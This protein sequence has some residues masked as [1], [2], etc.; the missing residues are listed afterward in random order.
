M[1]HLHSLLQGLCGAALAGAL[2]GLGEAAWLL[3]SGGAPDLLS[4][5]YAVCL[6]G[7]IAAPI[8]AGVGLLASAAKV[9]PGVAWGLGGAAGWTPLALFVARYQVN[10]VVFEERGV[11][12][13]TLLG[14]AVGVLIVAAIW[15]LIGRAVGARNPRALGLASNLG[16]GGGLAAVTGAVALIPVG[17]DPR[18]GFAHHKPIPPAL[19]D[20]PNVVLIMVDTLRADAL[21]TYGAG[22]KTP[23]IDAFA[24]DA[25]VFERAYS[26]ASWTRA[27]GASLMTSR[28]PSG[29]NAALK[30]ARLPND[31]VTWAEVMQGGGVTTAAFINNINLTSTFNF[32]QGYDTFV[33]EAPAYPFGATES[34]FSLT[35]YKVV[36]KLNERLFEKNHKVVE[37]FY[38][39][40]HVV[41]GDAQAFVQA[42]RDARWGMFVHLMEPHDPYFEHPSLD[43]AGPDY[44]GKGFDRAANEVP[45]PELADY[46]KRVYAGEVTFLDRQLASYFDWLKNEGLYDDTLIVITADHGEEFFEHGGWW[47]GTTLY[48]EQTHIPLLVK[49][50]K[51]RLAGTRVP[52]TVRSIDVAPTLAAQLGLASGDK[53]EGR[54]LVADVDG[55]LADEAAARA[56]AAAAAAVPSDPAAVPADAAGGQ[57]PPAAAPAP[58][59]PAD[60]CAGYAHPRD[61]VV[62]A[63]ENFEGNILSAIRRGG[64]KLATANAGNPRGLAE[65][66]LFD[67]VTDAGE[68]VDLSGSTSTLCGGETGSARVASLQQE[69]LA[70]IAASASGATDGG[71]A[72]LSDEERKALEALGYLNAVDGPAQP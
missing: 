44:N 65:V 2:L 34:V 50:P 51:N 48:E 5:F 52:F 66:T 67:L 7:L 28:L 27:S 9:R 56:A 22:G 26:Q 70:S 58:S 68:R 43:G 62:I 72:E 18:D 13:P 71:Q 25:V 31:V 41:L 47:H 8:G 59:A 21:G 11:P 24:R 35:L 32:Q 4:P 63:E 39:P 64:Y 14:L 29:H 1:K 42:N 69:L 30:A 49:L 57:A 45:Q 55:W 6:Y 36:H 38:Q 23:A 60:P 3:S 19:A 37:R 10:K 12:L 61:R 17:G 16:V 15:A 54:D 33:Y 40:A 53:W 46:L 20:R